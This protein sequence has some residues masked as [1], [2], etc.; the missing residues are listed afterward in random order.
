MKKIDSITKKLME[1]FVAQFEL[2]KEAHSQGRCSYPVLVLC[3]AEEQR[4]KMILKSLSNQKL[5]PKKTQT[6]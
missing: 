2:D 3:A 4:I 6:N 1:E 5:C